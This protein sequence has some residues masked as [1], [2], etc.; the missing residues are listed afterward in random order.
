M[1]NSKKPNI[2]YILTDQ[3]R[4]SALGYAGN[5][6]VKTRN[7][8]AFAKKTVNYTNT[9]SLTPVCTPHRAALLIGKFPSTTGMFLNELYLPSEEL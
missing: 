1:N 6:D 9:V 4:S 3:W 5:S 7:L 8:D 2:A